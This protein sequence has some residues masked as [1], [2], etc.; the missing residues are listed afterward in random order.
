MTFV[1]FAGI[2]LKNIDQFLVIKE[3]AG[4]IPAGFIKLMPN[5]PYFLMNLDFTTE[6][7]AVSTSI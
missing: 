1:V 2:R 7:S 5:K 3:P 6:P 4:R